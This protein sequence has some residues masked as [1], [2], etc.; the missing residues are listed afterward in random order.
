MDRN[1][2]TGENIRK[3]RK[4]RGLTLEELAAQ[5]GKTDGTL[6]KYERNE[7]PIKSGVLEKIAI[8]L[9]VSP[10]VLMGYDIEEEKVF[11]TDN[12]EVPNL[13]EVAGGIP[14][15]AIEDRTE[16]FSITNALADTGEFCTFDI[17]GDSMAPRINDGD[18]VLVK[19]QPMVS[20]GDVAILY[21]ND[22]Q[23]TCK[24]VFFLEN[25]KVKIQAYNEDVYATKIFTKKELEEMNFK[26]L[27]KVVLVVR[28]EF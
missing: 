18:V 4:M 16:K 8:A 24:K 25:G 1:K 21:M 28:N 22:Y 15:D 17:K 3:Y 11:G 7:V 23:V 2:I 20:S 19:Y 5:I 27:G 13:G 10:T 12:V 9:H 14:V 26:I 6:S